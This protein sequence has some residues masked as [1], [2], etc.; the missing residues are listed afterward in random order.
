MVEREFRT[1]EDVRSELHG[2]YEARD[3]GRSFGAYELRRYRSL[4]ALEHR[5]IM[6]R[7][8]GV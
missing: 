5:L 8:G 3:S 4:L 6:Q 7:N 2:M 1:L